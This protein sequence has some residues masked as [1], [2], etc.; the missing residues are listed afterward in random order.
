VSWKSF[1]WVEFQNIKSLPDLAKLS[2][3]SAG[4]IWRVAPLSA[5]LHLTV[6]LNSLAQDR[7]RWKL[8]TR[9]AMDTN[10]RWYHGSW[11]SKGVSI[12]ISTHVSMYDC[13]WAYPGTTS[14]NFTKSSMH[15]IYLCSSVVLWQHYNMC[16]L[17]LCRWN[18][19]TKLVECDVCEC[20]VT[21]GWV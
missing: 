19:Q 20:L 8:I 11:R 17:Q 9:Q 13:P 21:L 3:S 15:V 12:V 2:S 10:G 18:Q 7:R 1:K 6:T 14:P 4:E 5:Y 16:I